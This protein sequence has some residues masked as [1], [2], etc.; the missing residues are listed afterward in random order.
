MISLNNFFFSFQNHSPTP[1]AILISKIIFEV[2]LQYFSQ[3]SFE[4]MHMEL[5]IKSVFPSLVSFLALKAPVSNYKVSFRVTVHF[6]QT[7]WKE[8]VKILREFNLRN[9]VLSSR[10]LPN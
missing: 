10:D 8:A 4:A 7:Y 1:Q 2:L 5:P 3:M 9:H 6:L